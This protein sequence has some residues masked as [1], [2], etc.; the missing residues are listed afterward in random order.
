MEQQL[1]VRVLGAAELAVG[2]RPL[3]E[4]ASAKAAA[5]VVYLAVTGWRSSEATIGVNQ[6]PRWQPVLT[7][8]TGP[9]LDPQLQRSTI[10]A[11]APQA[12]SGQAMTS[13][14]EGSSP[15]GSTWVA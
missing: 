6:W 13:G 9:S 10:L 1:R 8:S 12:G 15:W 14:M 4:L 5:L 2:G 3:V 11:G 7:C